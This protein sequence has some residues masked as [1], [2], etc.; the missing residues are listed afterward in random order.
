MLLTSLRNDMY[1]ITQLERKDKYGVLKKGE[2]E[3]LV[4]YVKKM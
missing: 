4:P 1:R 3:S 2:E